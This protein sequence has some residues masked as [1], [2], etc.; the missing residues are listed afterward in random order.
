MEYTATVFAYIVTINSY[1]L[2]LYSHTGHASTTEDI[3]VATT[4]WDKL[5]S[6]SPYKPV[7]L[8]TILSSS[9]WKTP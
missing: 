4:L 5:M 8:L 3:M 7:H 6:T 2:P 1:D 9:A